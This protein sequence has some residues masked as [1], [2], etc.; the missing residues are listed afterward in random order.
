M[1]NCNALTQSDL[2][3]GKAYLFAK[4]R[5][6][7]IRRNLLLFLIFFFFGEEIAI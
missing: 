1:T 3:L 5:W 2:S 7:S 6:G 4:D